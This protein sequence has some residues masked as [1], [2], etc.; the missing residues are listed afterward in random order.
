M[1]DSILWRYW[2]S[3]AV[4]ASPAIPL[5]YVWRRLAVSSRVA[6]MVEIL[7][8]AAATL[9]TIWFDAAV[10]NWRFLGGLYGQLHYV[11]LDGNFVAVSLAA[12]LSF[13]SSFS[14]VTRRQRLTAGI[15]CLML[16]LEWGWFR[17][18]NR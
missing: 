9:S 13:F 12:L 6:T 5:A 1:G 3:W 8:L 15:A 2:L 7:P 4:F 10:A 18:I 11:I 14:P 17:I 16:T